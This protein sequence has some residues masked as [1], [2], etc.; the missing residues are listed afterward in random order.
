MQITELIT[1]GLAKLYTNQ[2]TFTRYLDVR[3]LHG[4]SEFLQASGA[5]HLTVKYGDECIEICHPDFLRH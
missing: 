4:F 2:K 5:C 1:R 3:N